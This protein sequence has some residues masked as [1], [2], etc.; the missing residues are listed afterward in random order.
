MRSNGRNVVKEKAKKVIHG[1]VNSE[2]MIVPPGG[3]V[4]VIRKS[5]SKSLELVEGKEACAVIE[6]TSV[7]IAVG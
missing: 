2:I 6:A 4:S 5:L 3:I 7:M 1:E